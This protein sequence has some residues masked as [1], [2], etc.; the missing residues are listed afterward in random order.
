V[1]TGLEFSQP[2]RLLV[3]TNTQKHQ[4]APIKMKLLADAYG[5]KDLKKMPA[6]VAQ[7]LLRRK[8]KQSSSVER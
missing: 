1:L 4:V 8:D 3:H 7:K 6:S 2:N 5:S